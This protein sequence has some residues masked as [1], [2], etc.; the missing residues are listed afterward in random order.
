MEVLT[1]LI[2]IVILVTIYIKTQPKKIKPI[3]EYFEED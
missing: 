1:G 2:M 3:D